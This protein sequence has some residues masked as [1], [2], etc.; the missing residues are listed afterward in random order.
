M[1]YN[2]FVPGICHIRIGV[3]WSLNCILCSVVH[4]NRAYRGLQNEEKGQDYTNNRKSIFLSSDV[5]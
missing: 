4:F 1:D 2:P 5:G 3:I